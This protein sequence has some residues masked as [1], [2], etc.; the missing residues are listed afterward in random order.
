MPIPEDIV[1][2]RFVWDLGLGRAQ[3]DQALFGFHMARR[4]Q[5]GVVVDWQADTQ[6][7]ADKCLAKWKQRMVHPGFW[8]VTTVLNRV[9][10]FHL[11][12]A[13][14]HALNKAVAPATGANAYAGTSTGASLPFEVSMAVSLYGYVP[15]G[16]VPDAKNKRGRFYLPPFDTGSLGVGQDAGLFNPPF[17]VQV[18]DDIAAFCDDVKGLELEP[19]ALPGTAGDPMDLVVLS[20]PKVAAYPVASIRCGTVP[21]SQRRRRQQQHETYINR[22]LTPV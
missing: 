7:V 19:S 8:P 3:P 18:A 4:H 12:A 22:N 13:T 11:E 2:V 1:R 21:D 16:F 14:G 15:G 6:T 10:A 17:V 9:E 5:A 20:K